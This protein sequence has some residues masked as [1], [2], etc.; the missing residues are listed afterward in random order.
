MLFFSAPLRGGRV[1]GD[2]RWSTRYR[3]GVAARVGWWTDDD[4]R[5]AG[6]VIAELSLGGASLMVDGGPPPAGS[7]TIRVD[8]GGASDRV[9]AELV[10]VRP[11]RRGPTVLHARFA[12][13][14]PHGFFLAALPEFAA[15]APDRCEGR[16]APPPLGPRPRPLAQGVDSA[17]ASASASRGASMSRRITTSSRIA[18]SLAWSSRPSPLP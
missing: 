10:S 3:S 9:R 12:E 5:T 1:D 18:L 2:R 6:T 14:C 17:S 16:S 4:Y 8:A 11:T 13:P 7:V 15:T